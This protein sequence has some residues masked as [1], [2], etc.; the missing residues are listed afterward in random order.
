MSSSDMPEL[1]SK[2]SLISK[3]DIRY[4]GK[5]FTVDPQE[6]TIA[7]ANVK[8]FGT[9]DRQTTHPVP[10]QNQIYDYI[11]FRASD[12]KD[13][14]VVPP[15]QLLYDPAILQ[16]SATPA[17]G[18]SNR[19]S[20]A[21][22]SAS[23][24]AETNTGYHP[25]IGNMSSGQYQGFNPMQ[26]GLQTLARPSPSEFLHQGNLDFLSGSRSSTPG[27][28]KPSPSMDQA[29]QANRKSS[30]PHQEVRNRNQREMGNRMDKQITRTFN[31]RNDNYNQNR[32]RN[33][34]NQQSHQNHQ[35]RDSNGPKSWGQQQQSKNNQ[36]QGLGQMNRINKGQRTQQRQQQNFPRAPGASRKQQQPLKFESDYDFDKANNEFEEIRS[37]LSSMK[38]ETQNAAPAAPVLNGDDKKDDSGNETVIGN[39]VEALQEDVFFYNKTKSFFDN[40]SCEAVERSKGSIQRIDWRKERKLNTETFGFLSARRGGNGMYRG[41]QRGGYYYQGGGRGGYGYGGRGNFRPFRQTKPT[42]RPQQ[43]PQAANA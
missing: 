26:S 31:M 8:S 19:F 35:N 17:M 27:L 25:I 4:E 15:T 11:L 9:E 7:L 42:P 22:V 38:I 39:D 16:L 43:Q 3:A 29:T 32:N 5:L 24:Q 23:S 14:S 1:G 28:H 18:N 41:G 6:C 21:P 13:I 30:P 12:I 33:N 2:I 37:K 36:Q 40:I 20:N 34:Y 10:P